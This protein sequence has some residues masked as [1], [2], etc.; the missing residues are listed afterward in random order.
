MCTLFTTHTLHLTSLPTLRLPLGAVQPTG[1]YVGVRYAVA[2][3]SKHLSVTL[4][5]GRGFFTPPPPHRVRNASLMMRTSASPSLCMAQALSQIQGHLPLLSALTWQVVHRCRITRHC[6]HPLMA[7]LLTAE[8]VTLRRLLLSLQFP[9]FLDLAGVQ[10]LEDLDG[11]SLKS[12]FLGREEE[13]V[14]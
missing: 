1:T 2:L 3:S 5:G 11:R 4:S 14:L 8:E 10:P 13:E 7:S 9:T 12:I 6:Q